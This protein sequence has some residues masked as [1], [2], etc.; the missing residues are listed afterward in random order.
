MDKA[1]KEQRAA[2]V[3]RMK[4]AFEIEGTATEQQIA[5]MEKYE[6]EMGKE[7][8][9]LYDDYMW[10]R[11]TLEEFAKDMPHPHNNAI[12]VFGGEEMPYSENRDER[13]AG[14]NESAKKFLSKGQ[15][16]KMLLPVLLTKCN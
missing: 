12:I 11:G 9:A 1:T 13:L 2:L 5:L 15:T 8:S 6:A 7:L 10:E 4:L 14:K 3:E 16:K